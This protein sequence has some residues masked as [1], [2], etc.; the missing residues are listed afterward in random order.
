MR[1]FLILIV[2]LAFVSAGI[3]VVAKKV[4]DDIQSF[5]IPELTLDF[6]NNVSE[7]DS[8]KVYENEYFEDN[9]SGLK[10]IITT[11]IPRLYINSDR[12]KFVSDVFEE[13]N[14]SLAINGGYFLED[15]SHAGLLEV[16]GQILKR[17]ALN[18]TQLTGL[19]L[20]RDNEIR[21]E[22]LSDIYSVDG[23]TV[24]QTG[25]IFIDQ[26]VIQT[27]NIQKAANGSGKYIRSFIGTTNSNEIVI[28]VSTKFTDLETLGNLLIS[29]P[30]LKNKEIKVV[31]LDGGSSTFLYSRENSKFQV[32]TYR[33]L[34]F[35]VG[36]P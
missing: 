35:I 21:I 22:K 19:V 34:P 5:K 29:N 7:D 6:T 2:F 4:I 32:N 24:F 8:N 16:N 18:D 25:P 10:F 11:K 14:F 13:M 1:K 30:K 27:E 23:N 20:F 31:N 12:E 28:G 15:W 26:G 33:T 9:K 17:E 3:Y 36:F